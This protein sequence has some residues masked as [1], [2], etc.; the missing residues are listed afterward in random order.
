M[1]EMGYFPLWKNLTPR[2]LGVWFSR[3]SEIFSHLA[4]IMRGGKSLI[5][6]VRDTA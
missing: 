5:P 1:Y 2:F 3:R 6:K 4:K